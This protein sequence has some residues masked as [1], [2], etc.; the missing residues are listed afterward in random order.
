MYHRQTIIVRNQKSE[1]VVFIAYI[2]VARV[3]HV[4]RGEDELHKRKTNLLHG[5]SCW[6][7]WVRSRAKTLL[8]RGRVFRAV[9]PAIVVFPCSVELDT[10]PVQHAGNADVPSTQ[11]EK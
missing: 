11:L 7:S 6:F 10:K 4:E 1:V 8:S 9:S 5:Q 2:R 3:V